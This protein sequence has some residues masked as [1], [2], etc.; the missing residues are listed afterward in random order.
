[1]LQFSHNSLQCFI[2]SCNPGGG[3]GSGEGRMKKFLPRRPTDTKRR[4]KIFL[5]IFF[6]S[7]LLFPASHHHSSLRL[8]LLFLIFVLPARP[9]RR[10]EKFFLSDRRA[11]ARTL[12]LNTPPLPTMKSGAKPPKK[13]CLSHFPGGPTA[14]PGGFAPPGRMP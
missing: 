7:F 10:K 8:H 11:I 3:M 2:Q 9:H 12:P 14:R 13:I 5:T 1:M 4:R 6:Y